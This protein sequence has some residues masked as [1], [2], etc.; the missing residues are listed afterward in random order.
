MRGYCER[1]EGDVVRLVKDLVPLG[2]LYVCR[3]CYEECLR[4]AGVAV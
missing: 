1:C 2:D 3:Q 4:I